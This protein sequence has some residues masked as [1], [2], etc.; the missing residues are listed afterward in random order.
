L[1]IVGIA[2]CGFGLFH[3]IPTV[4]MDSTLF[5]NLI[6]GEVNVVLAADAQSATDSSADLARAFNAEDLRVYCVNTVYNIRVLNGLLRKRYGPDYPIDDKRNKMC[7]FGSSQH[8][9]LGRNHDLQSELGWDKYDV[10]IVT[11]WEMAAR[12]YRYRQELLFDLTELSSR[13]VT[14]VIYSTTSTEPQAGRADRAGIGKLGLVA[15][16]IISIAK[17]YHSNIGL[18]LADM[19]EAARQSW[20]EAYDEFIREQERKKREREAV[21]SAGVPPTPGSEQRA[22]GILVA[23]ECGQDARATKPE[24]ALLSDRKINE[25]GTLQPGFWGEEWEGVLDAERPELHSHAERG[26]EDFT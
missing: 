12:S 1:K 20:P 19:R 9:E 13:G 5:S 11:T 16:N 7:F 6:R 3:P 17:K 8:G 2:S 24:G 4:T 15:T 21:R 10:L 23:S 22:S 25:L 14:I 26:N 18:S